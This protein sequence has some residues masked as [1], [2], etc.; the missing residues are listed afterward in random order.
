MVCV[1]GWIWLVFLLLA[2]YVTDFPEQCLVACCMENRCPG[3]TCKSTDRGSPLESPFRDEK[4]TLETLRKHQQGRD[5][6]QFERLGLHA[7]Y[8]PFWANLPHC[9]IFGSFT[10]D[11]LHQLHKGIFKDHLVQWCTRVIG[12]K[13]LDKR[14]KAMNGYQGLRH[15]KKGIL[16]VSQWTGTEHKEMEKIFPRNK[17]RRCPR[18]LYPSRTIPSR[19]H[20]LIP[21]AIPHL[22][23]AQIT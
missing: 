18:S 9:N 4:E 8:N 17:H 1:D 3:C 12:E 10:S 7:V 11:L 23:D 21:V 2:A 19:L 22:H 13:E 6:P 15:F 16:L 5:P 20:I 14:F